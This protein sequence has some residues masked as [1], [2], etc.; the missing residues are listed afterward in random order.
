MGHIRGPNRMTQR[1]SSAASTGG[2]FI[3]AGQQVRLLPD[4]S[5]VIEQSTS[6]RLLPS[7]SVLKE[8]A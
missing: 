6:V 7:G 2:W 5:V 8:T 3:G 4:G 1:G